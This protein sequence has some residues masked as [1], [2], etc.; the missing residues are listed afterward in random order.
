MPMTR[1]ARLLRRCAVALPLAAAACSLESA[2]PVPTVESVPI[3]SATF[4][5]SLNVDLAASTRTATGLY[6]RD[7]TVGSGTV[8]APGM[9]VTAHYSGALTSG[10]VFDDNAPPDAPLSFVLGV[11][12]V[13]P[14][15]D[16]G[17]VGMRVGG[18]RQLIVP[19]SLGYGAA[20][21]SAIPANSILVFTVQL[22][23]AR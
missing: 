13:I 7:L 23:S 1:L 8:A 19:P 21:S 9:S 5:P 16:E 10:T 11:G 17:V 15:W 4:A 14:G 20:S 6:Y 3:E 2:A 18:R 22:A 12:R